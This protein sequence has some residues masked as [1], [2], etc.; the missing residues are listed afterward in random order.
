ML[1]LMVTWMMLTWLFASVGVK[2]YKKDDINKA[3]L[4][5]MSSTYL[6]EP[7]LQV[8]K[9]L[10][11]KS[12]VAID[13]AS[14]HQKQDQCDE[15]LTSLGEACSDLLELVRNEGEIDTLISEG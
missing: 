12:G 11:D 2:L 15:Q 3:I 13:A 6:V 8:F 7:A 1:L 5:A 10:S 9:E 4:A 14:I